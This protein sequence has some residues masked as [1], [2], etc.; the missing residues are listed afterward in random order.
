MPLPDRVWDFAP[1]HVSSAPPTTDVAESVMDVDDSAK[2]DSSA[3]A[4]GESIRLSRVTQ[5]KRAKAET[6]VVASQ[7]RTAKK[8]AGAHASSSSSSQ[9]SRKKTNAKASDQTEFTSFDSMKGLK[10]GD[11]VRIF[12]TAKND[13]CDA[14]VI[15]SDRT[16]VTLKTIENGR[17]F[18]LSQSDFEIASSKGVHFFGVRR[19]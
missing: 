11:N 3:P 1:S 16:C 17:E 15:F 8:S 9:K 4:V 10:V 2:V 14:E 18:N 19:Q 5:T 13:N 6:P 7:Q 12:R